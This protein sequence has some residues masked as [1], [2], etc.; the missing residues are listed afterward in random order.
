MVSTQPTT[1]V[2]Q[3]QA[4]IEIFCP[5]ASDTRNL[6]QDTL[7]LNPEPLVLNL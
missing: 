6:T 2:G 1:E 4:E 3:E 7:T 5:L